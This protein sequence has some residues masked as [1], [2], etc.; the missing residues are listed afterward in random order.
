MG[1]ID[2]TFYG[3]LNESNFQERYREVL[4]GIMRILRCDIQIFIEKES[5]F[6]SMRI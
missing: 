2:R 6:S 1:K 3:G 5:E 4:K